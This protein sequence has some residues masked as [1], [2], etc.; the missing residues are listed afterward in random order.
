M[1]FLYSVTITEAQVPEKR[2]RN[3]IATYASTK[4]YA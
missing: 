3:F 4:K 1:N 2:P